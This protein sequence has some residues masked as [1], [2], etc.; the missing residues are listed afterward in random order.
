[1]A[2]T[3]LVLYRTLWLGH[4]TQEALETNLEV[5]EGWNLIT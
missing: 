3:G 1:M 5:Y 4:G 2:E